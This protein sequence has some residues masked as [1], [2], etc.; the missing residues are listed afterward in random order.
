MSFASY[1]KQLCKIVLSSSFVLGLI[2]GISLF[3]F[4]EMSMNLDA[5]LDFGGPE[6]LLLIV[7]VPLVSVLVFLLLSPLSFL[8]LK[9]MS[10][11]RDGSPPSDDE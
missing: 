11:K 4:G 9:L 2:L 10:M 8:I 5:D 7:A 3:L 1:T 6:S